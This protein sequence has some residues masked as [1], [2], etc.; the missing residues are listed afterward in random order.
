MTLQ[1]SYDLVHKKHFLLLSMLKTVLFYIYINN[2]KLQYFES[3]YTFF[4]IHY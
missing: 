4:R 1:E 3:W 2:I